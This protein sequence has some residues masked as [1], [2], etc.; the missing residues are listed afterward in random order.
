MCAKVDYYTGSIF[1]LFF[2]ACVL[3]FGAVIYFSACRCLF[4]TWKG[5]GAWLGRQVTWHGCSLMPISAL[6]ARVVPAPYCFMRPA[7]HCHV[8]VVFGRL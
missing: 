5:G 2:F 1:G 6:G 4:A 3:F 8:A 7:G